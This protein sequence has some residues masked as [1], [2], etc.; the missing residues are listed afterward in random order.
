V[1]F[2]PST[3]PQRDENLVYRTISGE[4]VLIPIRS[5]AA[6]LDHLFVLNPTAAVIW[7]LLDGT[8][9]LTEIVGRVVEEF[10]V[11]PAVAEQD[12]QRLLETL[13]ESGLVG[14]ASP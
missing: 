4:T 13:H 14:V 1:S 8:R 10:E 11:D 7:Q 9:T 5:G 2:L 6:D 3:R 12:L